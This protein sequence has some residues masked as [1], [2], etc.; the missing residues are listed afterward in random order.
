MNL[1]E[2]G[3]AL[4]HLAEQAVRRRFKGDRNFP[5]LEIEC[6]LIEVARL[7][8]DGR[9]AEGGMPCEWKLL[10][11]GE[12]SH[13]DAV[14]ALGRRVARNDEGGF[15]ETRLARDR[16]HLGVAQTARVDEHRNRISLQRARTE[17]VDRD[18]WK[19]A[20]PMYLPK[21]ARAGN[22]DVEFL[23]HQ[24]ARL[25]AGARERRSVEGWRIFSI[26]DEPRQRLPCAVG[27]HD[28]ASA[29]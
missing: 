19:F 16:L 3:I 9:G 21:I 17:D 29:E 5:N 8:D 23:E 2:F 20:H 10:G 14:R 18:E 11:D 27:L 13:L 7:C 24:A 4:R 15:R 22:L 28:A 25:E 26:R 12:N 6:D 1:A